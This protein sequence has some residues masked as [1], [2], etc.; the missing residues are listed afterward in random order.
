MAAKHAFVTVS[1]RIDQDI[2]KEAVHVLAEIGLTPEEAFRI[3][4]RR[5]AAE[6]EM[7]FDVLIP[8]AETVEAI[9]AARRGEVTM[10]NTVEELFEYLNSDD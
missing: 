8:N 9:E 5:I 2:K 1:A 6:G 3:M 4:M 10:C 7:P